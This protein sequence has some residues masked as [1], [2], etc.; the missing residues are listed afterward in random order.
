M[1]SMDIVLTQILVIL[2][3][4]ALGF[5]AGKSGLV[6]PDQRKYL[7]R[8]C[9]S[10]VLP[11]TILG[12]SS[13]TVSGGEL[14]G[15][16]LS[17]GVILLLFAAT[18]FLSTRVQTLRHVPE[19]ARVTTTSLLTYPNCTFLGL[20]LCRA[21]FG[22]S[23]VLYNVMYMLAFN[24]MFF[25]WQI[26]AFTGK[27]FNL[28]NL[29]TLP[30]AATLLL[31]VML[32]LGWHL[33]DP[34]QT[35]VSNTGAMITPLSLIIIGV[36]MSE[37]RLAVI[38]KERRAYL[39]TL[40]RNLVIPLIAMLPI[41]LLSPDPA[42]RL[43]LLVYMAC[44]CATLTSIYAIQT[45]KEPEYAARSTLMSTLFFALTLPAMIWIGGIFLR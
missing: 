25:T 34:V 45:G 3:Y 6:S 8:V 7:T 13:Q 44:P 39:V 24:I 26:T 35:V 20:P 9:T 42:S 33:P 14:A 4:V 1:P 27:K 37:N 43:C 32:A 2:L 11:C 41:R 29:V 28:R 15:M 12:A 17:T 38:L 16:G 23:A 5:A 21:L 30:T 19:A 36:M 31:V 22:E 18:A 10:L 40:F